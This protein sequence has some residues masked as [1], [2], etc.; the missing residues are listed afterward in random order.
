VII[1]RLASTRV[2]ASGVSLLFRTIVALASSPVVG[3]EVLDLASS[4]WFGRRFWGFCCSVML[5][6][7]DVWFLDCFLVTVSW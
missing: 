5:F 6:C 3:V 2:I 1:F 7:L 4:W